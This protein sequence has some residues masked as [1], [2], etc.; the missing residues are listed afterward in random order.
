ML[1]IAALLC[2]AI[3]VAHSYL[4]ERY[5]LER[6]LRKTQIPH[7][8]GSD[9][10]T[11]RTLRFAWHL[12][13]IAWWGLGYLVWAASQEEPNLRLIILWTVGLVFFTSGA[14]ALVASRGKHLS[15][16]VFWAIAALTLFAGTSS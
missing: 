6:L 7:L 4:G 14:I 2:F 3:G 12:T 1:I 8:F 10:F 16:V 5:I 11:K 9:L 15:W 13:T